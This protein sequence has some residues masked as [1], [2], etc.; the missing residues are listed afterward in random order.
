MSNQRNDSPASTSVKN[1]PAGNAANNQNAC[2]NGK[3]KEVANTSNGG[4]TRLY[5]LTRREAAEVSNVVVTGIF[6][7]CSFD[8]YSL[9]DPGS[10]LSYV[11]PYFALD[12]GMEPE[13]LLEP[14]AVDTPLDIPVIA[15]R[16]Y[17]NCVIVIK[18]RETMADLYELELVD[19]DVIMGMDCLSACYANVDCHLSD[20]PKVFSKDLLGIPPDRVID[21]GIDVI[22]YT[23]P[24]FIPP[25]RMAPVE[26]RELKD[27][28]KD[29]LDKGFI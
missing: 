16:V 14:F 2:G 17:R 23:Q 15:S 22:P 6:T 10:K 1:L 9:I 28:L 7:I 3:G 4:T 25:Y 21:F 19:F 12:F 27:Q 18:G 13:R 8:A 20:Y 29:L 24:I 5:G 11:T 26:L